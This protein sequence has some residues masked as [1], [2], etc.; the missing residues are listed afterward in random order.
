[1]STGASGGSTTGMGGSMS[2]GGAAGT[3]G[4]AAGRGGASG[5]AGASGAGRGGGGGAGGGRDA[6]G[7][8]PCISGE[9]GPCGGFVA[10]ACRCAEG[11]VC[12]YP[13]VPD[14]PGVCRKPDA[15]MEHSCFPTCNRCVS[16][17]CCGQEC[18]GK[19]EWCDMSTGVPTCKCGNQPSCV[20]PN[21]CQPFG[22]STGNGCGDVCCSTLCPQ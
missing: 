21:T 18:C 11:L 17:I 14:V 15:G 5:S 16:G 8:G 7:D 13:G 22:P 20:S 10:N 19:G 1:M 12:R 4:G 9:G 3:S 2:T 6:G